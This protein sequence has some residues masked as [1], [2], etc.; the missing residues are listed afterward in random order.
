MVVVSRHAVQ[1]GAFESLEIVDCCW[2]VLVSVHSLLCLVVGW[3]VVEQHSSPQLIAADSGVSSTVPH[4]QPPR[5]GGCG[6]LVLLGL[7]LCL[8]LEVV[9][10]FVLLCFHLPVAALDLLKVLYLFL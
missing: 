9:H 4:W 10:Y 3:F 1:R 6:Y 8:L 2:P 5:V 7:V